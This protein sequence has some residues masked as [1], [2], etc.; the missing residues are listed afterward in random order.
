MPFVGRDSH[1]LDTFER[2][3]LAVLRADPNTRVVEVA[4]SSLDRSVRTA[5]PVIMGEVCVSCHNS[6][7][8][9][10]KQDW[11][12][13]DVRGIQEVSVVQPIAAN[14][15]SFKY[16]LVYF[17]GSG[18][19]GVTFIALQQRQSSLIRNMNRE[20]ADSNEFLAAISMK[21]AKYL[22][23]QVYKSIFSGQKD[24]IISTE[25]RNSQYSFLT[26][27]DFTGHL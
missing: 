17:A 8:G 26:I 24:V 3:A 16:L 9:S 25:R 19:A 4:G 13:G 2:N 12:V 1:Q 21:I 6:H 27:K 22:S 20:L 18:L 23:P 11:K 15:F 10:P 7:P 14:I 5:S